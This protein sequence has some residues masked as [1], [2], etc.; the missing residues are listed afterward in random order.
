MNRPDITGQPGSTFP[1]KLVDQLRRDYGLRI[2]IETGT[3]PLGN[4]AAYCSK[5]FDQVFTIELDPGMHA[6]A[7]KALADCPRVEALFGQSVNVLPLIFPRLDKPTLW[8]LDAHWSGCGMPRL[9]I[10]CP[11]L[12]ELRMI[13]GLRGTDVI[14]IDDARLFMAP[15]GGKHRSEEWPTFDQI[16]ALLASWS[17]PPSLSI[18]GDVIVVVPKEMSA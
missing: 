5:Q 6:R 2:F 8:W 7:K 1:S 17:P 14:L 13:G 10:E 12:D 16:K 4:T 9:A 18:K 11:L 15:P 3:G